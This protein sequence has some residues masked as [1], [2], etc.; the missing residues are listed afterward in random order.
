MPENDRFSSW[1]FLKTEIQY[2]SV[3][4]RLCPR[5]TSTSL[6]GKKI[7]QLVN[8][9]GQHTNALFLLF[10]ISFKW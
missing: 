8:H 7:P 4:S 3:R 9:K 10:L 6:G 1:L 5:A 2:G